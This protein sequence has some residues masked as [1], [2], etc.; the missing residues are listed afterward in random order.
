MNKIFYVD[1]I[2]EI[3]K[4]DEGYCAVFKYDIV[5]DKIAETVEITVDAAYEPKK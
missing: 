2:K 3:K 4:P 5:A 1:D